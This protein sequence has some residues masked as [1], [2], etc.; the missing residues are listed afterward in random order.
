MFKRLLK[1]LSQTIHLSSTTVIALVVLFIAIFDNYAFWSS[2]LAVV[3]LSDPGI[4]LFLFA[5]FAFIFS[6]T[7]I[8]ITVL[9]PRK[10][11]KPVLIFFLI[12]AAL[13]SYYMDN[14]NTVF[15][16][17]MVLSVLQ[18]NANEAFELFD[19]GVLL[20]VLIFGIIPALFLTRVRIIQYTI[21]REMYRRVLSTVAVLLIAS[22]SIYVS[23]KNFA[24]V[25]REHR[26]ISFYVNPVYPLRSVYRVAEK[27]Y[28]HSHRQ[29]VSIFTDAHA[30][31]PLDEKNVLIMVVG[32]T[33][34][35]QN[36]HLNGYARE[37]TPELEKLDIVNF[38][39]VSSCGT[40]TAVSV[41]CMFSDLTH[42]NFDDNKARD[43]QNL[44]DALNTAG[45]QVLWRE[46]NPDCKGVCDRIETQQVADF[47]EADL[48]KQ[49]TCYDD[50]LFNGLDQYINNVRG[51]AVIVLHTEGSH[52][53][54]YYRRYPEAFDKFKPECRTA[55]VESCT[56]E[57]LS[58]AYDNT[59]LYTDHFLSKVIRHLKA[60][61]KI[62][63]TAMLYVSDHGESLGENGVYLHGLPYMM[64]PEYQTHV[65][66]ILWASKTFASRKKL[67]MGCL[68]RK[69][70][71]TLSQ[72][73]IIHSVLGI[74][75][76][77]SH[78]YDA[79]LD[80]FASCR[81]TG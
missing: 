29:F 51:D 11:L 21:S 58:N 3:D 36:F 43:Q 19:P 48:C 68:T 73:N 18:T 49:G 16:D 81:E 41:P 59:I 15:D 52:G 5:C 28:H 61:T 38:K 14:Y 9:F 7:Y 76:V 13:T 74:M 26:E 12:L 33:A 65:P 79:K 80:M 53:P 39:N 72:D 56:N 8:F 23:Y 17:V 6:V 67:D 50:V 34:R 75:D 10:A 4:Y 24:L 63:S 35:A 54:A 32:E 77:S 31:T 44:L 46:N 66:M 40:A 37:T 30:T 42:E 62:K 25:F 64:A 2:L 47:Y 78:L 1:Q 69:S 55:S 45:V 57:E 60:S 22:S 27:S 20:H 70:D 71:K